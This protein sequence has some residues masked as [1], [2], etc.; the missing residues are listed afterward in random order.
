MGPCF[1]VRSRQIGK[2]LDWCLVAEAFEAGSIV[3]VDELVEEGVAIGM[4]NEGAASAATL[5]LP[6][7]SF[8][9]PPIEAFDHTVGLRMVGFGQPMFDAAL[10][11]ETVEGVVT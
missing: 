6:A 1:R 10:L 9:D 4:T 2:G 8:G 11:A 5:F 3:I 7:D